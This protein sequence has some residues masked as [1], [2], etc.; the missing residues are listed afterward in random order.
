[1]Q[2]ADSQTRAE[3]AATNQEI[4]QQFKNAQCWADNNIKDKS[5]CY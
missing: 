4:R 1:M 2:Q 5:R 3:D